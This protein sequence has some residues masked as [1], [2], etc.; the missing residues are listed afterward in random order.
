MTIRALAL[1]LVA[2][3]TGCSNHPPMKSVEYVD[4]DRYMGDWYV[5]ANIPTFVETGAHNAIESY[6]LNADGSIATTF[7]FN[8][9]SFEGER[10]K[11]QP[12]G[13]IID[14]HSNAVWGMQ[15]IWPFK[16]DYRIVYVKEDY[17][18]TVVA[19]E[20]R[21]YVWVMSRSPVIEDAEYT[22]LVGLITALGYKRAEIQRVPQSWPD[23]NG[24]QT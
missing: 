4:I 5:I 6:A 23:L 10:K 7:S 24:E 12:T 1:A 22:R 18:V 13:F 17:S 8:D 19:R 21:D 20:A 9:E 16:A 11:Y 14:R 3:L 15:F 2:A